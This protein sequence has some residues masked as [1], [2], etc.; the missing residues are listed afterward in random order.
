MEKEIIKL[1]NEL[2]TRV[3]H[4]YPVGVE[5]FSSVYNGQKELLQI[6][7][8][9][10]DKE[11]NTTDSEFNVFC[12]KLQDSLP[13]LKVEN[14]IY[15]QFPNYVACVNLPPS[16]YKDIIHRANFVICI[17]LLAN[18]YTLYFEESYFFSSYKGAA[19]VDKNL[20]LPSYNI[21]SFEMNEKL[22][23][24]IDVSSIKRTVESFFPVK[25]F[26]SHFLIKKWTMKGTVPYGELDDPQNNN[27]YYSIFEF[28][29]AG[30]SEMRYPAVEIIE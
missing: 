13:D 28:L 1:K 12:E 4:F 23:N 3:H 5:D 16:E 14:R 21:H 22:K 24:V 20:S 9:K 19:L 15:Y 27:N 18:Y 8:N 17:S 6:V 2:I 29:F 30:S 26:I 7:E 10:I 25:K 11:V